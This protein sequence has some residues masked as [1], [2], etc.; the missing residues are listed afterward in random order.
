MIIFIVLVFS[1]LPLEPLWYSSR[2]GHAKVCCIHAQ[3][4]QQTSSQNALSQRHHLSPQKA[5]CV[6][7]I[8]PT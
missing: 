5:W 1:I 3:T 2:D 4:N 7:Q 6:S 8:H